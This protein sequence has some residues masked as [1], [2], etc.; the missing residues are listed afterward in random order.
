MQGVYG[1]VRELVRSG[2][3]VTK[4][5]EEC[6]ERV[7]RDVYATWIIRRVRLCCGVTHDDASMLLTYRS[8]L[9]ILRV[10]KASVNL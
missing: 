7:S 2:S 5:V 9:T 10:W 4:K 6:C 8:D 3:K 1:G